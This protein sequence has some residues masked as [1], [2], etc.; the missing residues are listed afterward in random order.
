[1]GLCTWFRTNIRD[2]SLSTFCCGWE[3]VDPGVVAGVPYGCG[4]SHFCCVSANEGTFPREPA[5]AG[6]AAA[7][8]WRVPVFAFMTPPPS[9]ER[10]R[11]MSLGP[12]CPLELSG[13]GV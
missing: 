12:S 10:V 9:D 4:S 6:L 8:F 2:G 1:M 13:A 11:R 3:F 5:V 7:G